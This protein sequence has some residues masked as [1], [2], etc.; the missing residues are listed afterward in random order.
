MIKVMAA[1]QFR[2]VIAKLY[3]A[4]DQQSQGNGARLIKTSAINGQPPLW[5]LSASANGGYAILAAHSGKAITV[6]GSTKGSLIYQN[7]NNENVSRRWFFNPVEQ[8][9]STSGVSGFASL[10]GA[11]GLATTTGGGQQAPISITSCAQLTSAL[12]G[13][14]PA[15]IQ[16]PQGASIDC[17]TANRAQAACAIQCPSNQDPRKWFYRV[18]VGSQSCTE[19]GATNNKTTTRN[20]NESRIQVGSNKTIQGL[21]NNSKVIGATFNLQKSK[22]VIFRN[23]KIENINPEL[24]EAGDGITL[25]AS[26]HVLIEH[27]K[28]SLISDGHVDIANSQNITLNNNEFDGYNA[29]VCGSQH[30][31]TNMIQDSQVTLHHNYWNTA[32]GRNPK[33][34]GVNARVHLY[35]NHWR[36]ITYFSVN[37]DKGA[38]VR[39][40][41]NV[42]ENSARP[43]WNAGN[44]YIDARISSNIYSGRS[45]TSTQDSGS[46]WVLNDTPAYPY[47]A[48]PASR[49]LPLKVGPQ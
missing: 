8:P 13:D 19:L 34:D 30:H 37:A 40:E 9:C 2:R 3:L 42:F 17:R 44:G 31:Y 45:L 14:A 25:D 21:G 10:P 26:S 49:L 46:D 22:N 33:V 23:F 16:I 1:G 39:L 29:A 35:N 47:Q 36:N 20:R 24:I 11:D 18:P 32:S 38:Q 28:F 27:M 48:E 12:R 6:A 15:V 7:T 43:H 41:H 5:T 4:V